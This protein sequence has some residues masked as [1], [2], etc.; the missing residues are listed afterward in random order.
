MD[1]QVVF[2]AAPK[3]QCGGFLLPFWDTSQ[4]GTPFLKAWAC[5]NCQ[6]TA[7]FKSGEM[8]FGKENEGRVR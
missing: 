4:S 5:M 3:C 6:S 1:A 2:N 8:I 7:V